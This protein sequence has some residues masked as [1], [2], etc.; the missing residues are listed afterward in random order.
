M[1]ASLYPGYSVSDIIS[2]I[3][4][5]AQL[6]SALKEKGGASSDY[7]QIIRDVNRL[8]YILQEIQKTPR[9]ETNTSHFRFICSTASELKTTLEEFVDSINK[10][11]EALGPEWRRSEWIPRKLQWQVVES[12]KVKAL[13]SK[14]AFQ[15][16]IIEMLYQLLLA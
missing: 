16:L 12:P 5:V 13:Q 10:Y 8:E 4:W 14:I 7:Q 2:G 1:M 6:L 3:K 11:D 9:T 15:F